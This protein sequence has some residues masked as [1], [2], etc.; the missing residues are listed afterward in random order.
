MAQVNRSALVMFSAAQ[1]YDLVNDVASYPQFLPGCVGSKIISVDGNV[2]TASVDVAKAGISKTFTTSNTLVANERV[3]MRLVD[4]PF[5]S[6]QGGWQFTALDDNACK[7]SLDLEFEFSNK[8]AEIA[9]G[10][11][12]KDLVINMVAAFTERAKVVYG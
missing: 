1:M 4:G 8:L 12:F 6:L 3:D 11:V 2:M 7:V 9:F 5:K 10:K